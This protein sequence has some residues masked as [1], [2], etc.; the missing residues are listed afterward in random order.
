MKNGQ[1]FWRNSNNKHK[2]KEK[3]TNDKNQPKVNDHPPIS[4]NNKTLPNAKNRYFMGNVK[5]KFGFVKIRGRCI[6]TF[7]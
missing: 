2:D 7:K 6:E 1:L 4:N 3:S 5:C